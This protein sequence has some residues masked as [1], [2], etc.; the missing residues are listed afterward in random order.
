MSVDGSIN[1]AGVARIA[2]GGRNRRMG[3]VMKGTVCH[4]IV[5]NSVAVVSFI[6]TAHRVRSKSVAD[7]ANRQ[8]VGL[9]R[10]FRFLALTELAASPLDPHD[11]PVL[12]RVLLQAD[13]D[14]RQHALQPFAVCTAAA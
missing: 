8:N 9:G 3:F 12:G 5:S 13:P 1:K 6:D 4:V 14:T 2:G 11:A 10:G 7:T